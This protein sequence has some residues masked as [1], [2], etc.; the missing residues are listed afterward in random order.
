MPATT[1]TQFPTIAISPST[2]H[3]PHSFS[4]PIGQDRTGTGSEWIS[5][6]SSYC[7]ASPLDPLPLWVG[8]HYLGVQPPG[9]FLLPACRIVPLPHCLITPTL[10][11]QPYP[12][13]TPAH[14]YHT[15]PPPPPYPHPH[16][17]RTLVVDTP[18]QCPCPCPT[19][20]HCWCY[21]MCAQVGPFLPWDYCLCGLI[22][23][24][25]GC[26]SAAGLVTQPWDDVSWF[27]LDFYLPILY[28]CYLPHPP[29]CVFVTLWL[30]APHPHPTP[31]PHILPHTLPPVVFLVTLYLVPQLLGLVVVPTVTP[32]V[33]FIVQLPYCCCSERQTFPHYSYSYT[34]QPPSLDLYLFPL[35]YIALAIIIVVVCYLFGFLRVP[36]P[37]CC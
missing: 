30:V 16:L 34:T 21:P 19:D 13:C 6:R 31:L 23:A 33:L 7:C 12:G 35:Y 26:V 1:T 2:P 29:G 15:P 11:P 14:L 27:K 20:R 32:S 37:I 3:V 5:S 10:L 25:F 22:C 28:L 17:P 8:R 9:P 4:Q 18:L 24:C 36:S